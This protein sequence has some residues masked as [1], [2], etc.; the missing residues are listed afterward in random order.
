VTGNGKEIANSQLAE[1]TVLAGQNQQVT[2]DLSKLAINTSSEYHLIIEAHAKDGFHPLLE[3]NHKVAWQQFSITSPQFD[4]IKVSNE[5]KLS[6]HQG[7]D[8]IEISGKEFSLAFDK[9]SGVINSYKVKGTEIFKQ[10]FSG[11]FWRVPTDNDKGWGLQD[12]T[13]VW[14]LAS[15]EQTLTN[16]SLEQV[17]GTQVKVVT[18]YS[19]ANG[20]AD[21]SL[22][23]FVSADGQITIDS[24]FTS[25]NEKLPVMPRV[26]LH[27]EL[28]GEFDQINWFGRGPHENYADR[29]ESAAVGIYQSSV[30]EQ[31][32]DYARPQESGTKSDI[33]WVDI[34][35]QSGVGIQVTSDQLFAFSAVPLAKFDL[36]K[37]KEQPKHSANVEF[38]DITTLKLD[39]L[40]MGVGGDNSWGAKPHKEFM[41]PAK[42]YHYSFT[43]KPVTCK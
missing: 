11:N 41:I 4:A 1:L 34:T 35:N 12:V 36:Y 39:Y 31:I 23:Y 27:A 8:S 28:K 20:V 16:I 42:E 13:K 17:D 3:Q 21:L 29:K 5:S 38:K 43:L 18:D 2:L 32:H 30:D 15:Q 25:L 19:L 6:V 10:G 22:S 9:S 33:R 14:M 24:V 7:A 40:H 37:P 26:G